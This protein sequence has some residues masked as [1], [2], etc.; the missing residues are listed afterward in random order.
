MNH[1]AITVLA[2]TLCL[3]ISSSSPAAIT[4]NHGTFSGDSVTFVD[5]TEDNGGS[6]THF[7]D[8]ETIIDMLAFD[9]VNF[10]VQDNDPASSDLLDSELDMM[11][12][13]HDGFAIDTVSFSES[14]DYTIVTE[15]IVGASVPYFWEINQ[16]DGVAI[17]PITGSGIDSFSS[18]TPGTGI[19]S[20]DFAIDLTA[21]LAAHEAINGEVGDFITKATVVFDNGVSA[22]GTNGGTA[23]IKKKRIGGLTVT[24]VPEPGTLVGLI[25][26]VVAIAMRRRSARA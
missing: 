24:V 9:P 20:L 18:S 19:W 8:F 13:A 3:L 25:V 7:E 16:V 11:I 4:F 15:G 21:E 22:D 5:V 12:E 1:K 10:G 17:L 23:F 26:G 2:A 6:Q 14:G